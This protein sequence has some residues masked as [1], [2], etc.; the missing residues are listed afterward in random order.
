MT[1]SGGEPTSQSAFSRSLLQG[2]KE[3]GIHTAMETCGH[4]RWAVWE[5]YLPHLDLVLYDLKQTDPERHQRWT[6]ASNELVLENLRRLAGSGVPVIVRRPV[7]PGYNDGA[8]AIHRLGRFVRDLET[9]EEI[10]LL[11]Y[12]GL[13]QSKYERLGQDYVLGNQPSLEH[14]DLEELREILLSYGFRVKIGG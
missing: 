8:E 6:G 13:G 5:S 4:A 9:V 10:D 7:I 3:L 14:S 12:H 2:C 11:P 1:L